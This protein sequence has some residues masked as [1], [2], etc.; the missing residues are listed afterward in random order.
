MSSEPPRDHEIDDVLTPKAR[1]FQIIDHQ[2]LKGG[3]V[4]SIDQRRVDNIVRP[5]RTAT[6]VCRSSYQP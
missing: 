6:T 5:A 3:S 4:E 1:A 2:P